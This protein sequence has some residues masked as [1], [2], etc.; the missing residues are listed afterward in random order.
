MNK[1]IVRARLSGIGGIL[2]TVCGI[3]PYGM[4]SLYMAQM[5]AEI[6]STVGQ[7]SIALS[8]TTIGG[9]IAS[10]LIGRLLKV[11]N[12]KIMIIFAG[13]CVFAFQLTMS[14]ATSIVP[15]YIVAFFNGLGITWGGIAMA[16]VIIA[17]WFVKGRGM[18]MSAC[19]IVIGIV[20]VVTIPIIGHLVAA[21]GY[22]PVLLA[23]GIVA[24]L[25][26][27][28]SA[29]LVSSAPEKYGLLPL[30]ASDANTEGGQT[31]ALSVPSLSWGKV[32]RSP[33]FWAIFLIVVL[34]SVAA[35][36]LSTQAAVIFAS[37]GLD[38]TS[39]AF[40]LSLVSLISLPLQFAFGFFCDR[41]GPKVTFLILAGISAAIL[42]VSFLLAGWVAAVVVA[43]AIAAVSSLG[44]LYGPNMG[45]RLFGTKDAG[46]IIGFLVMG[47][48]VGATIGPVVYGFMYDAFGN[49]SVTLVLMSLV[50][51]VCLVLNGW[52]NNK[53]NI[54]KVNGQ[55][56]EEA[57]L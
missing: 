39:A 41:I 19:M 28:I 23:V 53:R 45:P 17:Q 1:G 52:L 10:L 8:I 20:L 26:V 6:G 22:R 48:N 25:G 4:F 57:A 56:A 31:A 21:M 13:V 9:V 18:M 43:C 12:L 30:G 32:V 3:A 38:Q 7:V 37:F 35:S 11:L 51:V 54:E 42:L 5:A 29:F 14:I 50:L 15:I 44:S 40:A 24:G 33:V 46:D 27:I 2:M 47:G 36:G 49:Y 34:V 55:I 16:Q